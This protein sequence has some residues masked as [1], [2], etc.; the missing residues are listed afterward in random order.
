MPRDR[1][2]R[3]L[4]LLIAGVTA[5]RL[6]YV[7]FLSPYALVED[8]AH[9]W[10]WSRR[11]DLSYYSKGPGI[12]WL[13]ALGTSILGN[14]EAGVRL[15][16]PF[17]GAVLALATAAA[18]RAA[19]SDW[20]PALYAAAIALLIPAYQFLAIAM[21]I[22]GPYLA[23]WAIGIA[24]IALALL[25][26][27]RRGWLILGAAVALGFLFKYT[28]LLL[29]PGAILAALPVR[30]RFTNPERK[31][32]HLRA[33]AIGTAIAMMG[34][35]PV[36]IW[37]AQHDW[38]TVRHLLGHLGVAGGDIAKTTSPDPYNPLWTL[39]YFG[40]QAI[41]I[42]PALL[43]CLYGLRRARQE[44]P[45]AA[46]AA[47]CLAWTAAPILGFYFLVS[48]FTRVE[49]NWPL[50]GYLGLL[51]AAGWGVVAGLGLG[52]AAFHRRWA[53]R[54]TL[55]FG[56]LSAAL[57]SRLDLAAQLPGVGKIVPLGRLT[58]ARPI[59][60]SATA[61]L[62]QHDK[63]FVLAQ[64]YGRASL[65]AFYLEGNPTTFS[66]SAHTGGRQTQYD[67]WA[68][69]DLT[70]PETE[71]MLRGRPALILG[72]SEPQWLQLFERV[73]PL[74]PLEGDHKGRPAFLGYGYQGLPNQ[75]LPDRG[76]TP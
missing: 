16:A 2:L 40:V 9:Y 74:G 67:H 51:P 66:S 23:C 56:L 32:A 38:V 65:L 45:A 8:E 53:W 55:C 34:L 52:K 57:M 37:N 6:V 20:R 42:G 5:A 41:I 12:A 50:A 19:F 58:S 11:L 49:G 47:S 73:E 54:I 36:V 39:E 48:F 46:T 70:N 71:A 64:H 3:I 33:I 69:T 13:I 63:P 44:D 18:T 17:A 30:A 75:D 31:R 10:E 68:E 61:Q 72:G 21:T 29:I 60:Q 4:L 27:D 62:D 35:L 15:G 26:A 43:S 28:I 1:A 14:T 76:D 22:D 25:R 24:G 7:L 59:A